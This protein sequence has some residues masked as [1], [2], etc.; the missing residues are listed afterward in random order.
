MGQ[1]KKD[2]SQSAKE[3]ALCVCHLHDLTEG[4]MLLLM[5]SADNSKPPMIGQVPPTLPPTMTPSSPAVVPPVEPGRPV[6]L[7]P[8]SVPP[9]LALHPASAVVLLGIDNFFFGAEAITLELAWPILS[10]IAF[11]LTTTIVLV[12]QKF[13]HKDRGWLALAKALVCGILAGIPTS[14]GGTIFATMVL[15]WAGTTKL[16]SWL[17]KKD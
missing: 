13:M 12:I 3:A 8:A 17:G 16:S 2:C 7:P 11:F 5:P 4:S 14:I 6:R 10:A 15:L 9:R 1:H